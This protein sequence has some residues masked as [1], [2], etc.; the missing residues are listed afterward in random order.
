MVTVLV[1]V[2]VA[3]TGQVAAQE[4]PKIV[5][6]T[7]MLQAVDEHSFA[8]EAGADPDYT[9]WTWRPKLQF[10]VKGDLPSGAV[11]YTQYTQKG[12]PWVTVPCRSSVGTVSCDSPFPIEKQSRDI[13]EFGF[14][15]R[16]KNE[17]AGTDE[18]LYK[19]TFQVKKYFDGRPAP[20][21]K[22]TALSANME[23]DTWGR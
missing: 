9:I 18:S 13:G 19:G 23:W 7:I 8:A 21:Y 10:Y 5:V 6:P 22:K 3:W 14:E 1:A 15:I 16:V 17:L 2:L 20:A 11:L 4:A 12:K